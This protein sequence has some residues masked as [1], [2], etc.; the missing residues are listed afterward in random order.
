[1]DFGGKSQP[2]LGRRACGFRW[3]T[4]GRWTSLSER[5]RNENWC[6]FGGGGNVGRGLLSA[7]DPG[8]NRGLGKFELGECFPG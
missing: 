1:M 7:Q 4:G 8:G 6:T 2:L 5:Q 3:D